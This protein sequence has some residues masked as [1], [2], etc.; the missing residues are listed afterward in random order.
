MGLGMG[1]SKWDCKKHRA[2]K[3]FGTSVFPMSI[4]KY[5][6]NVKTAYLLFDNKGLAMMQDFM[7]T[8]VVFLNI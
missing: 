2:H 3:W 8:R 4:C 6:A 5:L 7:N 1:T